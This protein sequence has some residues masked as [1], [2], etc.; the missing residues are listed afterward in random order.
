MLTNYLTTIN[1]LIVL[2]TGRSSLLITGRTMSSVTPHIPTTLT[3][4]YSAYQFYTLYYSYRGRDYV[5]PIKML[6]ESVSNPTY[7]NVNVVRKPYVAQIA[8]GQ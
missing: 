1:V 3:D 2:T 4:P 8:C 5:L 6:S 7:I